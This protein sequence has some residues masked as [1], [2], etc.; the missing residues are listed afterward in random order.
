M[1]KQSYD[2]EHVIIAKVANWEKDARY[3]AMNNHRYSDK[4]RANELQ[5]LRRSWPTQEEFEVS[6]QHQ[7][8][9]N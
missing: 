8:N 1:E 5:R 6:Y 9:G 7:Q 2:M 4:E 3:Y